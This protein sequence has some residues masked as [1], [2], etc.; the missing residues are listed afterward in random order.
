MSLEHYPET[1]TFAKL[2]NR[3]NQMFSWV[4]AGEML[5]KLVGIGLK[6]YVRDKFNLFDALIVILS[7]VDNIMFY[8]VGR[9]ASGGGVMILRSIRLLRVFKLARNWKSLRYL[10]SKM[11]NTLP[12]LASF[13]LLLFV[14]LIVFVILGL[15][16]FPGAVYLDEN[17]KIVDADR[18]DPP[19]NNF[20]NL[21]NATT[22]V[23]TLMMTDN[24]NTVMYQYYRTLGIPAQIYF[25]GT[26]V[27]LN[28]VLLNL[29]LALFFESFE[30][31]T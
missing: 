26:V 13:G 5:V 12:N 31:P 21:Y 24:W 10:I 23:F 8:A 7:V 1:K 11:M 2:I 3:L 16:F 27:V 14:F 30:N 28:I 17:D 22:T 6:E 20:E 15:Q 4:F 9:K 18:G 25:V 19:L 29:F